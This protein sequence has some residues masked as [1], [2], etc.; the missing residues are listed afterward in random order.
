MKREIQGRYAVPG[1]V[2]EPS[3][4][5]RYWSS[6]NRFFWLI[7]TVT[8]LAMAGT[9]IAVARWADFY[10]STCQILVEE[11]EAS[12][13]QKKEIPKQAEKRGKR[14]YNTQLEIIRSRNVLRSVVKELNLRSHYGVFNDSEAVDILRL[15]TETWLTLDSQIINIKVKGSDPQVCADAANTVAKAYIRENIRQSFFIS[16]QILKWL[17]DHVRAEAE[18]DEAADPRDL[19]KKMDDPYFVQSLPSVIKDKTLRQLE[20]KQ[21]RHETILSDLRNRYTDVHPR[22]IGARENVDRLKEEI[23]QRIEIIVGGIKKELAGHFELQT[24][25]ILEKAKPPLQ[26][27]GPDRVRQIGVVSFAA[28][29]ISIFLACFLGSIVQTVN[30]EDDLAEFTDVPYLGHVPLGNKTNL[31]VPELLSDHVV[32]D[33]MTM[34]STALVFSMPRDRNQLIMVTSCVSSE[35][36]SSLAGLLALTMA[37]LGGD[38]KKL[39]AGTADKILL[40]ECDLRRPSFK[41]NLKL[42]NSGEKGMA[43]FL[44]GHADFD[45]IINPFPDQPNLDIITSGKDSPNPPALFTSSAFDDFVNIVRRRYTRVLFDV[46]PFLSIPEAA[47]ISQKVHGT[48]F[49]IGVGMIHQRALSKAMHKFRLLG[50]TVFGTVLNRLDLKK[51]RYYRNYYYKS[52]YYYDNKRRSNLR[53]KGES[54]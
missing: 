16:Q 8:C 50:C 44:V 17:P 31:S 53:K 20:A 11:V 26:P 46:P 43:D 4:F 21:E 15:N 32:A 1:E 7:M 54:S 3:E 25:K 13:L 28:F 34:L 24:V 45:E 2:S 19:L 48:M 18:K 27:A 41:K 42:E 29:A 37:R 12:H 49:I 30:N 10:E 14:F 38:A 52:Y 33:A 35:G 36:K 5:R 9:T 22:V 6:I 23:A 47:I 51:E 39:K 40:V